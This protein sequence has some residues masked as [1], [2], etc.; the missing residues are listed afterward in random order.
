MHVSISDP[1]RYIPSYIAFSAIFAAVLFAM[2]YIGSHIGSFYKTEDMSAVINNTL[3]TVII[4]AGHGGED[5]DRLI[6]CV[7]LYTIPSIIAS[8]FLKFAGIFLPY[9]IFDRILSPFSLVS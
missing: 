3:P 4:D 6:L 1:K 8:T 5:G 9:F 2:S 7:T